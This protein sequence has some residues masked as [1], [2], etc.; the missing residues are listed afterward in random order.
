MKKTF[1]VFLVVL[2][3]VGGGF[4]WKKLQ[5]EKAG[6]SDS[7][8]LS[9]ITQ[10]DIE[11]LV[12]AQGKLEPKEYV[13]VGTQVSGQIQKLFVEIGDV[14]DVDAP[15]AVIDPK[16]Y[17]TQVQS[18]TARLKT[19]E[20]QIKQQRA[21]L[22]LSRKRDARNRSLLKS[23][24]VSKEAAEQS[25]AEVKVAQASL[26]S[27]LAQ[28]EEAQSSLEAAQTNLGYT[29]ISAPMAGTVV[30]M[31][32]REGQT[33]NA[34]QTAPTIL[35]IAN[36]DVMTVRV[37]VAEA[38][39]SR[40]RPGMPAYF[41]TLGIDDRRWEGVLR[42][43]LPTP[44]TVNDVVLYHVLIDVENQDRLL[45]T[46]M[47]MQ[48]FFVVGQAND[49]PLIPVEALT[50]R[51]GEHYIVQV[52]TDQGVEDRKIKIGVRN[53]SFAQVVQGLEADEEIVL[54]DFVLPTSNAPARPRGPRL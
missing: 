16:I 25:E 31:P 22:D 52:K 38:D 42:Q 37:Q 8:R 44:E 10:G 54:Q 7:L 21:Q 48:V 29:R 34:S 1:V 41:T 14:V 33:V 17:E 27:L 3:A 47:S 35:Q 18:A 2:L 9:V 45:M 36:L 11:E 32:L 19:L 15:L 5:A 24:A 50:T 13:D 6:K 49:A 4:F 53:R 40:L 23:R 12:T 20:A 46:G 30:D 26:D 43:I 39:V 28:F 51:S